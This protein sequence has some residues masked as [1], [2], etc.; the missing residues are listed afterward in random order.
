MAKIMVGVSLAVRTRLAS[1]AFPRSVEHTR[2]V[3][4]RVRIVHGRQL[5][6]IRLYGAQATLC[7]R[8][9]RGVRCT[10]CGALVLYPPP[11][12]GRV[13]HLRRSTAPA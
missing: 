3:S 2:I 10:R 13:I 11:L 4:I 6:I 12:A 9:S 7:V 5:R 8:R 1:R